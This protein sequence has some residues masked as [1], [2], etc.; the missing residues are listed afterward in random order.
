M[1]KYTEMKK[2]CGFFLI[3]V[4]LSSCK[5]LN[6]SAMLKAPKDFKYT[7]LP[8][9]N[10]KEYRLKP[11]DRLTMKLFTNDGFKLLDITGNELNST[12]SGDNLTYTIE[13]DGTVR[14]PILGRVVIAELTDREAEQMLEDRYMEFYIKPF[15]MLTVTNR[16]VMVFPGSDGAAK[17]VLLSEGNNNL[18]QVIAMSGGILKTGRAYNIKVIRGDF[19]K[20][21]IYHF[22]IRTIDALKDLDF[23]IQSNDIVYVDP[24]PQIARNLF[25]EIGPYLSLLTSALLVWNVVVSKVK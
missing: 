14:L 10:I 22:N 25:T 17:E 11:N 19:D 24:S 3:L 8:A 18:L 7:Q 16:R 4:L 1:K 21:E 23:I 12:L 15:V 6:P 20:P 2:I 5:L 9:T 13:S